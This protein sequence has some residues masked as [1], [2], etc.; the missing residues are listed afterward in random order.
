MI[1]TVKKIKK[2]L[3]TIDFFIFFYM[4]KISLKKYLKNF[5]KSVDILF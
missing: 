4:V 5:K 3:K 2:Q 1:L